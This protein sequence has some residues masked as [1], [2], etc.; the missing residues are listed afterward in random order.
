MSFKSRAIWL[1]LAHSRHLHPWSD[2]LHGSLSLLDPADRLSFL[3]HYSRAL[4]RDQTTCEAATFRPRKKSYSRNSLALGRFLSM[5]IDHWQAKNADFRQIFRGPEYMTGD[6]LTE[7][8]GTGSPKK[9]ATLDGF[10][11]AMTSLQNEA[12]LFV[13]RTSRIPSLGRS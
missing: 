13:A 6:L 2:N 5:K 12:L 7:I 1:C 8:G 10:R 4:Q 11:G 3:G 9:V